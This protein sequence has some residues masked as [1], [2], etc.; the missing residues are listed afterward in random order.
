[1]SFLYAIA[2]AVIYAGKFAHHALRYSRHVLL[3]RVPSTGVS[4]L[5]LGRTSLAP[6]RLVRP[7]LVWE[8]A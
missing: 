1:M 3:A 6:A 4:S 5:N 8:A 2:V 7:L